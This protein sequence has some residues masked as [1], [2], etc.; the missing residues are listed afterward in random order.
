MFTVSSAR[1]LFAGLVFTLLFAS[2][3]V[4]GQQIHTCNIIHPPQASYN[5]APELPFVV[6]KAVSYKTNGS[7]Q[8]NL[9][10]A[11]STVT[12]RFMGGSNALRERVMRYAREWT[13]YANLDFRKVSSGYADIRVS[14]TQ[15]GASWSVVGQDSKRVPQNEPS[16]N[17]G[18]LNDQTSDAEVRRTVLHE[19]GHAIGL[20][21]EHQN[22]AGG[23]PWN[24]DAVYAHFYRSQG[25]DRKTTY[26]NVM[27]T[28]NRN[29]TQYSA[30]D[31][32]SI[33]HYPVDNRLTRGNYA[34][35]M[36]RE[37]SATD[38]YYVG[39]L[40]PGRTAE[41]A[42]Q[43]SR[44][45]NPPR[46]TAEPANRPEI[47]TFAIRISNQLGQNQQ[48]ETVELYVANRKHVIR[49]DRRGRVRETLDLKLRPGKYP[50]R[51]V[52]NSTYHGYRVIERGG[53]RYRQRV[54][55]D[56]PG[57]G[58]GT[59]TVSNDLSLTLYGNYD[60]QARRMRVYLGA[61]K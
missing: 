60:K 36:N 28:A 7:T 11:G 20:L 1:T 50:Y 37:L 40:Y 42:T 49:L 6:Q 56:I 17:L 44:P 8:S 39:L 13:R 43:P 29:Q 35:G 31:A 51:V 59:L 52:T 4:L 19:F 5:A 22:P 55:Q 33:M 10:P 24:E 32:A 58:S 54:T 47:A 46:P 25:W 34:V 15:N 3:P 61:S 9:W 57:N 48:A 41:T 2:A 21:H 12:V 16:M 18:W 53:R 30:Y 45:N 14:F 38:K 23:I 26:H 27:A